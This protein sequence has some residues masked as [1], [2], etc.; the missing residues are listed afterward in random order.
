MQ[1]FPKRLARSQRLLLLT[2]VEDEDAVLRDGEGSSPFGRPTP[3]ADAREVQ[4][5]IRI[6]PG[7]GGGVQKI[8]PTDWAPIGWRRESDAISSLFDRVPNPADT[9]AI[10]IARFLV[11]GVEIDGSVMVGPLRR[12]V[13]SFHCAP[14][15]APLLGAR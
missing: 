2:D 11:V 9:V 14:A 12:P 8:E 6:R 4:R 3:P 1:Q 10:C 13:F 5:E 15:L 7:I